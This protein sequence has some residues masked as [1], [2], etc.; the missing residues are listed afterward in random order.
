[1]AVAAS[2]ASRYYLTDTKIVKPSGAVTLS[3]VTNPSDFV[4]NGEFAYVTSQ[5]NHVIYKVNLSTGAGVVFA[6]AEGQLGSADGNA[7]TTRFNA[8]RGITFS[9][10]AL[11]VADSNNRLI[12][13][14]TLDGTSS[15]FSGS[16][17]L[18]NSDGDAA[19]AAYRSPV[20]LTADAAGNL[21]IVDAGAGV[22]RK[23][24]S[25]GAVTTIAGNGNRETLDGTGAAA[26]FR[27]P[28][29]IALGT[30]DGHPILFVGQD[31]AQIR[32]IQN[33]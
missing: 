4:V 20:D 10:N 5:A 23:A 30:L 25:T 14:V 3:G 26:A 22:I 17:Q 18:G 27:D 11:F 32:V 12:R 33:W 9:G 13:K 2:G 16:G 21:Y 15:R 7:T 6:G 8:P 19:T 24:S 29:S 1:V 28:S 31:D